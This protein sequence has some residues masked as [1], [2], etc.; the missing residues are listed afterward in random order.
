MGW[1]LK[2][3]W[4]GELWVIALCFCLPGVKQTH[5]TL[6]ENKA[7]SA[8]FCHL[9]PHLRKS[10]AVC[11][12]IETHQ[13]WECQIGK[14]VTNKQHILHVEAKALIESSNTRIQKLGLF[15][16]F[17][18][19]SQVLVLLMPLSVMPNLNYK[20]IYIFFCNNNYPQ[21]MIQL[22]ES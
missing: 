9:F 2:G 13:N 17:C 6:E 21:P 16:H 18:W 4:G 14:S 12:E 22:Y 5:C 8:A 20:N 10:L 15:C 7:F 3:S 1:Q 19:V 11:G